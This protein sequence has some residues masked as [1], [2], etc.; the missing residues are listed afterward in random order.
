ML[1]RDYELNYQNFYICDCISKITI[2]LYNLNMF[3]LTSN[4]IVSY[5]RYEEQNV[6]RSSNTL[7]HNIISRGLKNVNKN[8]LIYF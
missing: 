6:R 4:E 7:G 5:I 1:Y 3:F 2:S 8:I